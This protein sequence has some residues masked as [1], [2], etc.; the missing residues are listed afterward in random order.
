MAICVIAVVGVA[1]CQCF[2]PGENHT[3]SP[4]RPNFLS[5]AARALNPA[6]TRRDD[7]GLTERM[8][9]PSGAGS[10]L[11]R[12]AGAS[13]TCWFGR[14]EQRINANGAGEILRRSLT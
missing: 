11:E 13:H 12:D 8:C 4:G 9:V 1:P 3:T 14:L 7:Q 5:R 10:R 2:S 6:E